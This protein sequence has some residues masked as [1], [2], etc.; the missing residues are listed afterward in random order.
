M[1]KYISIAL[2]LLAMLLSFTAN[3]NPLPSNISPQQL[4]QFRKLSPSQQKAL[5]Q[6]MGLDFNAIK[7]QLNKKSQKGKSEEQ[8][9]QSFYPR[10]TKFDEFGNPLL[11]EGELELIKE[12][13]DDELKAFGY[14]IF[15]NEP[16]SFAPS[17]D[18]AVPEDYLIGPGDTV[19][20][21]MFG[22]ENEEFEVQ[23]SREGQVILP[24]YGPFTISGMTLIE[25]KKYL[26]AE[27]KNKVLGVDVVVTLSA[28]RSIRVFVLG[29]AYKPGQY[30]LN[31]LSSVTHA[32]IAAGGFND[33]GSLRNIQ[34]KRAGKLVS[35][36]DLYDLLIR[37][38]SSGD[39]VLK[40]NDVVFISAVGDQVSIDGEVKRPAIYELKN[41]ESFKDVIEMAGGMLPSAYPAATIVERFN[42]RNLR[43]V[44]NF[45]FSSDVELKKTAKGGDYVNV[46]PT[47][48]QF[49]DS[50]T[51][52]GAVTRPGKYQWHAEQR[53]I[54]LIPNINSYLLEDADLAY[55]IIIREKDLGRNIEVLQFSLFAALSDP[56]SKDNLVLEPGDKLLVF[57]NLEKQL[58]NLS[59]L[60][61]F[62]TTKEKL[63]EREKELAEKQFED[64][65][66]WDYYSGEN[67]ESAFN[68]IEEIDYAEETLKQ[69]YKS[70]E[71][72]TGVVNKELEIRELNFFSR[73]RLLAPVID[74]LKSQAGS[75]DPIMLIEVDGAVKY[76]G[77]YPL[78]NNGTLKD[79]VAAAGGLLESAFLS[80]AEITRDEIVNEEA[81]KRSLN[82][83]LASALNGNSSDNIKLNSKDRVN[84]HHIPAWQENHIVEL[85]GEFKFP[86]KYTIR[87]GE[88][89]GQLIERVGGFTEYADV[90]AS[91]FTREKLKQME[92]E[93]LIKVSESL[94][95]E[96][97]SKSLASRDGSQGVDYDQARKLL[98]D[99][100]RV[101][102]IGRLVVDIPDIVKYQQ[103]DVIL[104]NGD[105]LYIPTKQNSINVVGQVQVASSHIYK[106]RLDAFDYVALSGGMKK[107]AD[108]DRVYVIKANGQIHIPSN[109]SW[110]GAN[111]SQLQPGDTVVVPLDSYYM[112][113]LS[114]WQ[115][116]TQ[117]IYQ[118]AV[119]IAAISNL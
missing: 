56:T 119:A 74:K 37:G 60:D 113:D 34:I 105:I 20:V 31:A 81:F 97:A 88:S 11:L 102:P 54:D 71:E 95:M 57:S 82:I 51:I 33:V 36:L 27:I 8:K 83:N 5:A 21:Q 80:K 3:S 24:Q 100:T 106:E 79:A 77:L 38:D 84:I 76:P 59:T 18:I 43:T 101:E 109:N 25:A 96:I 116:A 99:L 103:A 68:Q 89:L 2:V 39:V 117:I 46:L 61:N 110:F 9:S 90:N 118:A 4:E 15:A 73:K 92:L 94:R 23:V 66:F 6:S 85:K 115:A 32:I 19:S 7:A 65:K 48:D 42:E 108:E 58:D 30:V 104:E 29:G 112:D 111:D 63:L 49:E 14:D 53:I 72:L 40:S 47:S 69:T 16:N 44:R 86:G 1:N 45:N 87:R 62:A 91:L 28:L 107:Q 50:L 17:M 41:G 67:K 55:S 26:S 78:A 13:Q 10:G 12:E 75:G 52:I 93:N 35:T 70:I 64:K 98:A 114:L 22:K